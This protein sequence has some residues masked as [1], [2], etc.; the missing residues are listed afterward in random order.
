MRVTYSLLLVDP[1]IELEL[2]GGLVASSCTCGAFL[3]ALDSHLVVTFGL[4]AQSL[5]FSTSPIKEFEHILFILGV[6]LCVAG[7]H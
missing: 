1:R 3:L 7:Y 4:P 2:V 5:S 6:S